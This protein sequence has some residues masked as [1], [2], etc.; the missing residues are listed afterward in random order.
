MIIVKN[1]GNFI[2]PLTILKPIAHPSP[3]LAVAVL[4]DGVD[5]VGAEREVLGV[6]DAAV[7]QSHLRVD[8]PVAPAVRVVVQVLLALLVLVHLNVRR[9]RIAL[10]RV[11]SAT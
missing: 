11:M 8:Q 2:K 3:E 5:E 9:I 6:L 10:S 1:Q 7:E 4:P